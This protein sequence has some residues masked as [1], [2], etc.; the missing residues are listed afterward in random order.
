MCE[1]FIEEKR[2]FLAAEVIRRSGQ[3]RIEI[4]DEIHFFDEGCQRLFSDC[5]ERQL[6]RFWVSQCQGA[7]KWIFDA[8]V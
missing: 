4:G 6:D 3:E 5:V 8:C 7:G 1:D 2:A